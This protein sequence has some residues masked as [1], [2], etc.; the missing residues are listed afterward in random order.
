MDKF[1]SA[2]CISF[3]K[4]DAT[5]AKL[6]LMIPHLPIS[7]RKILV[8]LSQTGFITL[9]HPRII[10]GLESSFQRYGEFPIP[11]SPALTHKKLRRI[12]V[13]LS[14]NCSWTAA[15]L[16]WLFCRCCE[17][18]GP[19]ESDDIL[20]EGIE[21]EVLA[22]QDLFSFDAINDYTILSHHSISL[23]R[24]LGYS[25]AAEQ[26]A[27]RFSI[28]IHRA[29]RNLSSSYLYPVVQRKKNVSAET[30]L[31]YRHHYPNSHPIDI[32][33]SDLERHYFLTGEKI[34]GRTEMR[35]SWK[36][37]D[38]KPRPYYCIGGRDYWQARHIRQIAVEFMNACPT[39]KIERRKDISLALLDVS[40]DD[41]LTLWDFTSFTTS[42]SE[43]RHF[44]YYLS[45]HLESFD[46]LHKHPLKLIDFRSDDP[47]THVYIWDLLDS[48]NESINRFSD[49][50]LVRVL[51]ILQLDDP[52]V[53]DMTQSNSGMLGIPGNIGFSTL[54]HAF[55]TEGQ[56][57]M[58]GRDVML[59]VGDDAFA[60]SL[61]NPHLR[62]IPHMSR[63]G[64]IHRDKF[65]VFNQQER[66]IQR[67]LGSSSS[68]D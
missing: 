22:S 2:V 39:S 47:I 24:G 33:T 37:N 52:S 56:S 42:L 30:S 53:T 16:I 59:C 25:P 62:L 34:Q 65:E 26:M 21:K 64:K 36:F 31:L 19:V 68:E 66:E 55:H 35:Y 6:L 1:L 8:D 14:D 20:K 49:F 38:L 44:L 17:E 11:G 4:T 58:Q 15:S 54:L 40:P 13:H 60:T 67:R 46:D 12:I 7:L 28:N 63:L 10:D 57:S 41:Y 3:G 43:L 23:Y 50:S 45:R 27:R 5:L 29:A 61:D 51:D 18:L 48:Y 32:H 9:D